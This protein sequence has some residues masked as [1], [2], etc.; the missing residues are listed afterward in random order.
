MKVDL[1]RLVMFL[2]LV[3]LITDH[4]LVIGWAHNK[5]R[6]SSVTSIA[7]IEVGEPPLVHYHDL[8]RMANNQTV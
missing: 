8:H 4:E 3:G 6:I 7:C 5:W 1:P 2:G